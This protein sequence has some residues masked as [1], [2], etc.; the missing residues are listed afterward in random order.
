MVNVL[1]IT[2]LSWIL[3]LWSYLWSVSS[4][5]NRSLPSLLLQ[6]F[7]V[8]WAKSCLM[9]SII[10]SVF[11]HFSSLLM[12]CHTLC[13]HNHKDHCSLNT[14]QLDCYGYRRSCFLPFLE[15][16]QVPPFTECLYSTNH[17]WTVNFTLKPLSHCTLVPENCRIAYCGNANTSRD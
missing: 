6:W 16:L 15:I 10:L 4:G 12:P 14:K 1:V 9:V 5:E 11:R 17:N 2:A 8:V 7:C 13:T 3:A